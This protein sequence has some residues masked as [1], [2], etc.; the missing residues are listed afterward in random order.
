MRGKERQK[1]EVIESEGSSSR[2]E[3]DHHHTGSSFPSV[4]ATAEPRAPWAPP[5]SR[6]SGPGR[7]F[8]AYESPAWNWSSG[9]AVLSASR[10]PGPIRLQFVLV[11]NWYGSL[12]SYKS[13]AHLCSLPCVCLTWRLTVRCRPALRPSPAATQNHHQPQLSQLLTSLL[14]DSWSLHIYIGFLFFN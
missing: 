10:S 4:R 5:Q 11:A 3:G 7:L 2:L 14:F 6:T 8:A 1:E 12:V 13:L 9:S